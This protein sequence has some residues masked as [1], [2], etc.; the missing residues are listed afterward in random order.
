MAA[1]Q[2]AVGINHVTVVPTNATRDD[3]NPIADGDA[4]ESDERAVSGG[5][6]RANDDT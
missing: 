6:S 1:K 2:P 3:D 5:D 4:D